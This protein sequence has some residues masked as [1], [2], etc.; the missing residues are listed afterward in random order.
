MSGEYIGG[1]L[2]WVAALLFTLA[3]V[4]LIRNTWRKR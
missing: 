2:C 4:L 3:A 1:V